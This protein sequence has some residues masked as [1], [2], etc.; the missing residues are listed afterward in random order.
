MA[1]RCDRD[2]VPTAS[3]FSLSV[4]ITEISRNARAT[5]FLEAT[6]FGTLLRRVACRPLG[7]DLTDRIFNSI[8]REQ[9]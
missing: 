1:T 4:M 8:K 5:S 2:A 7:L 6:A 9:R 3:R